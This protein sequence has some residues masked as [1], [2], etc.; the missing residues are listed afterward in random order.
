MTQESAPVLPVP[1]VRVLG[2]S[3]DF[4]SNRV[5][6]GVDLEFNS[7]S[8]HALLGANGSGKSTL[9]KILAGYHAPTEGRIELHGADLA[10]PATPSAVHSAGV[11]FVHQDLGLVN[12]MSVADN[13]ALALGYERRGG[14]I[15]WRGQRSAARMDLASVGVHDV[16]PNAVV[17]SLGPVQQ[18]LVAMARAMRGLEPGHGVLVLDEP[19]A[20]LP[21]AQVDELLDRCRLLRDQGIALIY[22]SHRLDEVFAMADTLSVLRD[23][24]VVFDGA[25]GATDEDRLTRIIT[26]KTAGSDAMSDE[27]ATDGRIAATDDHVKISLRGVGGTFVHGVDM[28]IH[29]GEILAVTGLVGSGRSELGRLIFGSQTKT[30]GEIRHNGELL[31]A[32]T[33]EQSIER[34]IGYVPQDRKQAAIPTFSLTDNISLAD[35]SKHLSSGR[36]SAKSERRTAESIISAMDVRPPDP[37]RLLGEL[38]G[39]NQQKI[40][41]GKWL[42]LD[43]DVLILDEPTYGVDIGAR[44]A[45]LTTVLARVA[46]TGMSLLLLDSDIDLVARY[47]DR[48]LV[49]RRGQIVAELRGEDVTTEKIA[50]ASYAVHNPGTASAAPGIQEQT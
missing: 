10:L 17:G 43:L 46:E 9:I 29:R 49:M 28:D 18:T 8:I 37:N 31:R 39:G 25:I 40:I 34:G 32:V 48:V 41:L 50:A 3:K 15:D 5:L 27:S 11:R 44:T 47:A 30:D 16:D 14:T 1:S 13:L 4:G 19:T 38:S 42:Q 23:G 35:L 24:R 12:T 20:R 22:V 6:D 2:L 7:G 45:I 36:I 33:I 26:G 21:N